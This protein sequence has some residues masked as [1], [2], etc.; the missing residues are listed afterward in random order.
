MRKSIVVVLVIACVAFAN[1]QNTRESCRE[2]AKKCEEIAATESTVNK[3]ISPECIEKDGEGYCDESFVDCMKSKAASEARELNERDPGLCYTVIC[4]GGGCVPQKLKGGEQ[5]ECVKSVCKENESGWHWEEEPT[6]LAKQ[7]SSDEC[8]YREC[9]AGKGCVGTDICTNRTTEC[10]SYSC[11]KNNQCVG[12][13]TELKDYECYHEVCKDGRVIIEWKNLTEACPKQ[14]M[15][16]EASCNRQGNCMYTDVPPPGEDPCIN[17]TCD[18]KDGWSESPKCDDGLFCTEDICS[19]AGECRFQKRN[20]ANEVPL[21]AC[22]MATCSE[23]KKKCQRKLTVN[24]QDRLTTKMCFEGQCLDEKAMTAKNWAVAFDLNETV[25]P[26]SVDTIE[27]AEVLSSLLSFEVKEQNAAIE[28]NPEGKSPSV[29]LLVADEEAARAIL[30]AVG[31][32]DKGADCNAGILCLCNRIRILGGH[33]T[34]DSS[35]DSGSE[36]GSK[37]SSTASSGY[38]SESGSKPTSKS[39]SVPITSSVRSSEA[40]ESEKSKIH[41]VE[42]GD[43]DAKACIFILLVTVLVSMMII[44]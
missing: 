41:S 22:Y 11:N 40:D 27:V 18:P 33:D 37:S 14:N 39:S 34:S 30:E 1:S 24:C 28:V 20:C 25:D 31:E 38:S 15:C 32:I 2:L 6:E 43:H 35:P 42:V 23:E 4:E 26:K 44:F 7:C 19:L 8:F 16:K 5:S 13:D 17:Y 36:S 3:C 9:V 12:F 21:S 10:T 29:L